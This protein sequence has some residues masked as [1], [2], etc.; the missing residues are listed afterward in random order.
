ME[1]GGGSCQGPWDIFHAGPDQPCQKEN[2]DKN[3]KNNRVVV[4]E[5]ETKNAEKR[6][7]A[8]AV[9]LKGLAKP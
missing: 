7:E 2:C 3:C 9:I 8:L 1:R 4:K 5:V 6:T